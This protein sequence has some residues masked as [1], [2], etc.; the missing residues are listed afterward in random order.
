M[1]S[2]TDAT[3]TRSQGYKVRAMN[4]TDRIRYELMNS[5]VPRNQ[6]AI[7][8]GIAPSQLSR[9]THGKIVP[10][11]ETI[12]VLANYFNLVLRKRNQPR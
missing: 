6:I 9:I 7:A 4:V 5:P 8:T 1:I 11:G 2:S 12:D 10:G 3:P